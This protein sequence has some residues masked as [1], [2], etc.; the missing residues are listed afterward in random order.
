M[1]HAR[2]VGGA[3]LTALMM[4]V[5]QAAP[6]L[7]TTLAISSFT[8]KTGHV[9]TSVFVTGSG[10][11]GATDT[12]FNGTSAPFYVTSDEPAQPSE[13]P[14]RLQTPA[15]SSRPVRA[16]G[17]VSRGGAGWDMPRHLLDAGEGDGPED[18]AL[19]SMRAHRNRTAQVPG[20]REG[21]P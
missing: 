8:P 17:D 20:A 12:A 1:K 7:A 21:K 9:G 2:S 14:P 13:P 3:L 15:H 19:D 10:F 11:T 5:L 4:V 6:S 18:R 16:E